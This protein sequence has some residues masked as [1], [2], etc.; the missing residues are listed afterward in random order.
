MG[1]NPAGIPT[2]GTM[3]LWLAQRISAA[4]QAGLVSGHGFSRAARKGK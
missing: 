3:S 1:G 2:A 4:I